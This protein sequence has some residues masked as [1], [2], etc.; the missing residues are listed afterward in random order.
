[1]IQDDAFRQAKILLISEDGA[2]RDTVSEVLRSAAFANTKVVEVASEAAME[3]GGFEP[4]LILLDIDLQGDDGIEVLQQ[5]KL[6]TPR[7]VSLPV[8]AFTGE[9]DP[10]QRR[11]A[12][13]EGASDIHVK[14]IDDIALLAAIRNLLEIRLLS[15]QME[16]GDALE[17]LVERLAR[18]RTSA[19]NDIQIE[20]LARFAQTAEYSGE[21]P[22]KHAEG[23]QF[24]SMMLARML[25]FPEDQ[26]QLIGKAS[27]LHDVG[28]VAVA[29]QIWSKPGRLT[30]TEYEKVKEHAQVGGDLLSEGKSPLLWLAEE[31]ARF[32]HERWD[33]TGY[34]G[35][36]GEQIPIAARIVAVADAYDALT[37]ERPYRPALTAQEAIDEI[38]RGAG[39][40]F[41]PRVVEAFLGAQGQ[42]GN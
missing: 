41:D 16:G 6:A 13:V 12:F 20:L 39:H 22:G 11:R 32:H 10:M 27:L 29:D 2:V 38:K 15:I 5:V 24:M 34:F 25:G 30:S 1:M 7:G 40:Q 4:D 19:Q 23:V 14:P 36:T 37:N 21:G 28:K 9:P 3:V 33:G 42:P 18:Q 8:L 31:I 17:D 26:A 35:L